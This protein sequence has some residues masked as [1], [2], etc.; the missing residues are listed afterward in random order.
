MSSTKGLS[1]FTC[2]RSTWFQTRLCNA[3]VS[4]RMRKTFVYLERLQMGKRLDRELS[5]LGEGSSPQRWEGEYDANKNPFVTLLRR[6][7]DMHKC[8]GN[9]CD[10]AELV[11]DV[12]KAAVTWAYNFSLLAFIGL[13]SSSL[14]SYVSGACMCSE[15]P[16][17]PIN[18]VFLY[19]GW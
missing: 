10:P 13:I 7:L 18:E 17:Y 8:S 2:A 14:G 15:I 11:F 9:T 5:E 19:L 1:A 16:Y 4:N 3:P 12:R 6:Q